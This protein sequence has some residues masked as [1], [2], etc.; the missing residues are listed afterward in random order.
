MKKFLFLLTAALA[1]MSMFAAPVDQATAMRKAK[2]YLTNELY[3]GKIMAPAAVNPVLLKAEMG[4]AKLGQPVYYIFNTSTTYLIMSGDDRA[5]EILMVGDAPLQ[6]INNLPLGMRD[7]LNIYK[8]EIMYLQEHPGLKVDKLPSPKNTPALQAVTIS[9]MLTAMWDQ[10]AP[11]WKYCKFTYNGTSYQCYTGCPATSASMV[12]YYW[13]YPLTVDAIPSYTAALELSYYNSVNFTYPA[14]EATTFDWPNMK[15][16]YTGSYTTAQGNAVATLMRYVGQAEYMMYG[17]ASA[18]GSGILVS[19]NYKIADMFKRFGYK[20]TAQNKMKSS[21]TEANWAA[22]IQG[23]LIAG[24]PLVYCAVSSEGGHAFNVDGYRDSDNKYHVNWGWSG[25]GNSWFAMN[26]F[27]DGS[28]T[29]SSQQQA[30]VGV[31]PPGGAVTAPTLTPDPSSLTFEGEVGG[32]YT[33][34]FTLSGTDVVADVNLSSNNS[35]FTVSPTTITAAQ[36]NAGRTI[37]VT[38]SPTAAGTRTG[39]ITISSLGA[40]DAT[41][42]VTGTATTSPKITTNPTSMTFSTNVGTAVTQNLK[43]YGTNLTSNIALAVSGTG[44]SINKTSISQGQAGAGVNVTVTYNPTTS[45]NHTGTITLTS[46]G[47]QTVTVPLN[48]TAEGAPV[49]T[50]Q[51]TPETLAFTTTVGTPVTK[52]FNVKG[53]N[54]TGAISLAVAGAGYTINKTSVTAA[55]AGA[56]VNVT[57]TYNPASYGTHSGTVTLTSPGAENVTVTLNGQASIVKYAPVMQPADEAYINLTQFRADWTDQTNENYVLSYTLEVSAKAVEPEPE[58]EPE[59]LNSIDGTTYTTQGYQ[60]VNLTAP[61]SGNNVYGGYGA[62]Y[63]RNAT[64]QSATTDG[65]IKYTIPAGYENKTFTLK[66]TTASGQYG[67]GRFVVG[68]TQTAA[69]EYSMSTASTHSWVVTGSTGDVIT[70]TSP[71][72]QYS[73]DIAKIEVWSGNATASKLMANETGNTTYRLITDI[74]DKFY[75]V[76]NLA[77]EGT[78]LYKV[79]ALYLDG[80]ESDWSNIEEVTLFQNGHGF[81]PGDVNHSGDVTIADVSALIDYLLDSTS[82]CCT[83]CADVNGMDG[84]TIADVSAL[85]DMLLGDGTTT[86]KPRAFNPNR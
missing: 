42:S 5:E 18:G 69:V 3:A 53:S 34:T 38:Y 71:E 46:D 57:V 27:N 75:I 85:I 13:K 61:W 54:L 25:S 67:S 66:L 36:A 76:E 64:H 8:E 19:E 50:I 22:L 23:E 83:I 82:P 45:G 28:A 37:T 47:A 35:L 33:K 74:T 70:I 11:Y 10:D 24:R 15:D 84:V 49:P 81:E 1:A 62:I 48:G 56:G 14:L 43:V 44:F 7:M 63:F 80:T 59:L 21:Y 65:Y 17:T 32:T 73:P 6:D 86:N 52:T 2:N 16:K 60:A 31:E 9:P 58:P 26:A 39:T 78:F 41:V 30:I 29:F 4:N 40:S 55:Q 77:A 68:S 79:K 51:A 72:D 20:S 12:L